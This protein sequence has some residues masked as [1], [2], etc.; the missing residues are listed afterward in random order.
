M[1]R[2]HRQYTLKNQ[3]PRFRE[4]RR[5][6]LIIISVSFVVSIAVLMFAVSK[7][8]RLQMFTLES[9]KIEGVPDELR[10]RAEQAVQ[11]TLQGSYLGLIAHS[12]SFLYSRSSVRDAIR[13]VVISA[14]EISVHRSG[15]RQLV[16]SVM[17]KHPSALVCPNLPDF[18]DTTLSPSIAGCYLADASG[19]PFALVEPES[20]ISYHRYYVPGMQ[21][22]T[23]TLAATSTPD[24]ALL[25]N[26]YSTVRSNGLDIQGILI[27]DG[28][29]Y[30]LYVSDV[31]VG[32]IVIHFNRTA[33]IRAE[34]DNLISFW[35]AM[36]KN[37]KNGQ[38]LHV[39]D[40][41]LQYP[42]NV[43]YT[44]AK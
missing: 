21:I 27:K 28:G 43:Y 14:D 6:R 15:L 37:P 36:I 23:S 35:N 1:H 41:K 12:N 7:I 42:P 4:E 8:S 29:E 3:S 33:D 2:S 30:E 19:V 20:V 10:S 38:P 26:V 18:S 22:G 9:V 17:E 40:I 5:R 11:A 34:I 44:E 24:F 32:T 31:T 16:V 13:S 39:S 25:E